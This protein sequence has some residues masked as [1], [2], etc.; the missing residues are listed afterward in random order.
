MGA[1]PERDG[2]EPGVSYKCEVPSP[3]Q[4]PQVYLYIINI[5]KEGF[6]IIYYNRV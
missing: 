2:T 3:L 4:K 1:E 6:C 5:N